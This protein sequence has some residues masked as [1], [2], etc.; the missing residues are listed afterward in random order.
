MKIIIF[1]AF[2]SF[3][4]VAEAAVLKVTPSSTTISVGSRITLQVAVDS[5][6][7]AVNTGTGTLSFPKEL[8]EVVSV[9]KSS[10]I[11]SVWIQTPTYDNDHSIS[12]TGGLPTPGYDG[13]NGR[14]FTVVLRAKAVG[15]AKI[16][17]LDSSLRAN[18]GSG[19]D[20]LRTIN[21]A[22]VTIK[23]IVVPAPKPV[24]PQTVATSTGATSTTTPVLVPEVPGVVS[25]VTA[26]ATP[27][28]TETS[29][30]AFT[31]RL[32]VGMLIALLALVIMNITLWTKLNRLERYI[33]KRKE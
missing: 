11:F 21:N 6:G 18:D 5:E 28:V 30:N 33:R 32:F 3:P 26:T 8:F 14:L 9:D 15:S 27:L 17:L 19:T 7:T 31:Q 29:S 13:S 16:V 24:V 12:F 10:S 20:V 2:L 1:F 4:F 25:L 22:T 23:E